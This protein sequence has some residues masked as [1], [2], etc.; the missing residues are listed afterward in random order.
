MNNY[1]IDYISDE[2][3]NKKPGLLLE[4]DPIFALILVLHLAT[5][6]YKP[7]EWN[8]LKSLLES[9]TLLTSSIK[10]NFLLLKLAT[11]LMALDIYKPEVLR[12][13][14]DEKFLSKI[15]KNIKGNFTF[16]LNLFLIF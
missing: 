15:L 13:T 10:P 5:T 7:K 6:D 14:L 3:V 4:G 11:S 12:A 1:L 9:T 16:Y 2:I 8:V